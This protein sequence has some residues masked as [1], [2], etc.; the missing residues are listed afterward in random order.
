MGYRCTQA[1]WLAGSLLITIAACGGP[2]ASVPA[3][4]P[5]RWPEFAARFIEEYFKAH[6]FFAVQAGRHEFDG[7]MDDV[8]AAGIAAE[9]AR[10]QRLRAEAEGFDSAVLTPD[11]RFER[12]YLLTV[13]DGDLFGLERARFPFT[14]PA[15]Y[16]DRLDPDVY[17]NRDYAPLP[18][19]MQGYI[20]YARAIPKIAADIRANLHTPLAP[21][22]IERG[23][24]G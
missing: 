7:Q 2:P 19:R 6:P 10:L 9:V 14:N 3:A 15:W 4:A 22:F 21:T 23:I 16:I 8:S 1:R 17:L 13:I 24:S 18:K 20:G 12:E 5:D 11:E